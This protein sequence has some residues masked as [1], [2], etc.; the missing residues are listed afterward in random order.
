[1]GGGEESSQFLAVQP[2]LLSPHCPLQS[3]P[4]PTPPNLPPTPLTAVLRHEQVGEVL[5]AEHGELGSGDRVGAEQ[6]SA[7]GLHGRCGR[8]M[9]PHHRIVVLH[10]DAGRG[11][12]RSAGRVHDRFQ[13][14]HYQGE[15][16]SPGGNA[17]GEPRQ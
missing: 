8:R 9:V 16:L 3:N 4:P 2:T 10:V 7:D 13:P 14:L 11:A 17:R 5:G 15:D 6:L 1:M 12:E